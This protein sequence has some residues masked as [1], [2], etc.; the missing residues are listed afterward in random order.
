MSALLVVNSP[1]PRSPNLGVRGDSAHFAC[2][3]P[4]PLLE[5]SYRRVEPTSSHASAVPDTEWVDREPLQEQPPR[6]RVQ[7]LRG[8]RPRRRPRSGSLRRGRR[9]DRPLDPRRGGPARP[10]GPGRVVRGQ[11]PQ[12]ARLRPRDQHRAGA[13]VVQEELPGVD[14]R[15]VLAPRH[16]RRARRHPRPLQPQLGDR[17]AGARRERPDLDVRRRAGVRGHRAPQRQRARPEDRPAHRRPPVEHHHGADRARRRLRRRRRP[18]QG[19]ARTTT[20][21][22]TSRASS[23]SS[24]RPRAT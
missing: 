7:P 5:L 20:A 8:A 18:G 15:G 1:C 21:P 2:A 4:C 24:P 16:P 23:A 22:G 17:R 12:P 10:R 9:R 14:G 3:P 6:H 19:H 11:R 13:R